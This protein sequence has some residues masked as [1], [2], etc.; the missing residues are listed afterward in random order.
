LIA[1][2]GGMLALQ[3]ATLAVP[4]LRTLLATTALRAADLGAIGLGA[5]APLAICEMLRAGG[6]SS[7]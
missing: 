4:P 5:V 1:G 6:G 7:G 3:A 2:I